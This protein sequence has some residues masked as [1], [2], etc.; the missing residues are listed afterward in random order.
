MKRVLVYTDK[1][2]FSEFKNAIE[3]QVEYVADLYSRLKEWDVTEI[4]FSDLIVIVNKTKTV[5]RVTS[6]S[7]TAFVFKPLEANVPA[8]QNVIEDYLKDK[9]ISQSEQP[10]VFGFNVSKEK[11]KDLIEVPTI[12][13]EIINSLDTLIEKSSHNGRNLLDLKY[14]E[15]LENKV[16]INQTTVKE[17]E[18]SC[19]FFVT[20]KKQIRLAEEIKK[21][22]EALN[23]FKEFGDGLFQLKVEAINAEHNAILMKNG[24]FYP[25]YNFITTFA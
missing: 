16:V 11:L 9:A 13:I 10:K 3:Q 6:N 2:R 15:L 18:E 7:S 19:S 8:L 5:E 14:F 20:T 24:K 21:V 23:N 1:S 4:T 12:P 22:C 25:D 17:F